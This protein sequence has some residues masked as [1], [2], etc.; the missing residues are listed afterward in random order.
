MQIEFLFKVKL[1][2]TFFKQSFNL[3]LD[4]YINFITGG[5]LLIEITLLSTYFI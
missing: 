5:Y 1:L 3:S 4:L 2:A